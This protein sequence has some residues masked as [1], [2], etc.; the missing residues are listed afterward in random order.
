VGINFSDMFGNSMPNIRLVF[1]C[2]LIKHDDDYMAWDAG[3]GINADPVA[4]KTSLVD[5]LAQVNVKPEQIKY[6]GISH[7]HGD[8]VGLVNSFPKST[9][10]IGKGDWEILSGPKLPPSVRRP[11]GDTVNSEPL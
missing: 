11:P 7:Y 5:L 1:S 4:P 10:L 9:L 2:Y 8:H 3:F 6:L